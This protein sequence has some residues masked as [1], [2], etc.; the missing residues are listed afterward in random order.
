[1]IH[2]IYRKTTENQN[3]EVQLGVSWASGGKYPERLFLGQIEA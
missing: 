3:H 2:Y 1:M